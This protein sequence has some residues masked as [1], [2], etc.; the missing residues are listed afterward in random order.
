MKSSLLV[1]S[2][3]SLSL[4]S[5]CAGFNQAVAAKE[6][7]GTIAVQTADDNL[8]TEIIDQLC[9]LPYG[10]V[11]RNQKIQTPVQS[12]CGTVAPPT[13]TVVTPVTQATVLSIPKTGN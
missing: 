10:A 8:V 1:I 4:L 9:L 2:I 12:A 3:L 7:S 6:K 13:V 5:S 11:V